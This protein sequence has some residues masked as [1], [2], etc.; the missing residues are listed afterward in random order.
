MP[1]NEVTV[2]RY[3]GIDYCIKNQLVSKSEI[4]SLI[5]SI[6]RKFPTHV[7][8]PVYLLVFDCSE[9]EDFQ[10][11]AHE[12]TKWVNMLYFDEDQQMQVYTATIETFWEEIREVYDEQSI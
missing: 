9:W 3:N 4:E 11:G 7:L 2:M 8:G 10:T 5:D 6:T 1:K 12:V